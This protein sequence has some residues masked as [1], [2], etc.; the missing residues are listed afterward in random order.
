MDDCY[1]LKEKTNINAFMSA[2]GLL[3]N[4]ALFAGYQTTPI[5]CI[6]DW[7]Q[8]SLEHGTNFIYFHQVLVDM[9]EN[10]LNKSDRR[11]FN[12]LLTT[13]SVIDFLNENVFF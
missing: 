5:E 3:Q 8:I 1:K 7:V 11:Y 4:P 13:S 9:L 12:T 10:V 6:K 2:R